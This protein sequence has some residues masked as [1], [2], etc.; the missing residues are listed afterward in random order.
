MKTDAKRLCF[1]FLS[2]LVLVTVCSSC[3]V[4]GPPLP[5]ERPADWS[6]EETSDRSESPQTSDKKE[7]QD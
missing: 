3:G 5:P 2:V 6:N 4:K 7:D 1:L